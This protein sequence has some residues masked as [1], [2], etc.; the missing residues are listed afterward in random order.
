M[1]VRRNGIVFLIILLVSIN[2]MPTTISNESSKFK[3]IIVPDDYP[4][5]QQAIDNASNG[6][7]IQVSSGIYYEN[8]VVY[9]S[10]SLQGENQ[11]NTFIDGMNK[12]DVINITANGVKISG[13]T[14][15]NSSGGKQ[16]DLY[17]SYAGIK[18]D[19]NSNE[20]YGNNITKNNGVG[21]YLKSSSQNAIHDNIIVNNTSDGICIYPSSSNDN[22]ILN[23]II[24]HNGETGIWV[25]S[26][27]GNLIKSNIITHNLDGV[28]L[29]NNC[30]GN[31]IVENNLSNN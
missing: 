15:Y 16:N 1:K 9:K 21:I 27:S 5:I 28:F 29:H 13:F 26:S 12:G 20:I 14:L 11:E 31:T 30:I 2:Y 22:E 25:F 23:N 18:I 24:S 17:F 3:T 4:T 19:S 6:D 7:I 10:V 8:L